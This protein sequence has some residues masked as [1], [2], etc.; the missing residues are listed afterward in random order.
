VSSESNTSSKPIQTRPEPIPNHRQDSI[1]FSHPSEEA[2]ARVL[3]FYEMEWE[4][5]PTTFPLEWDEEGRVTTAFSP[6]F[7]L[8]EEDLYIE[9][10]TMRQKLVTHKNRKLRLL[11]ELYPGVKCK[12]M[13]RK[14]VESMAVKYGL[15]EKSPRPDL[16]VTD[17]D[18]ENEEAEEMEEQP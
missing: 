9:L 10:T 1:R 11:H 7:Y 5:E 14:D 15:F 2:F 8:V 18:E 13:Y 16:C 12:L 6:D 4:Y 3:D 17:E